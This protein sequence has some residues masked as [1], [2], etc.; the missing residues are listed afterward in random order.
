M[1]NDLTQ[2]AITSVHGA[3]CNDNKWNIPSVGGFYSV[4]NTGAMITVVLNF[5]P[6]TVAVF[7]DAAWSSFGSDLLDSIDC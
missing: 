3:T 6:S 2:E 5:A 7:C 4:A 1:I